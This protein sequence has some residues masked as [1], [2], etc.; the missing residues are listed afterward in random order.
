MCSK[1]AYF[2]SQNRVEMLKTNETKV[3]NILKLVGLC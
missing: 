3:T 2:P 1:Q